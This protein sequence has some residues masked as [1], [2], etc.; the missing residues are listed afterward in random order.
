VLHLKQKREALAILVLSSLEFVSSYDVLV[1]S[2]SCF[3]L[4][5][6]WPWLA[7]V[8]FLS[9]LGLVPSLARPFHIPFS[10][11]F[12]NPHSVRPFSIPFPLTLTFL[13]YLKDKLTNTLNNINLPHPYPTL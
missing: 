7:L 12:L 3:G 11:G 1:L 9:C 4:A 2:L 8:F 13:T 10:T 6:S 5:M